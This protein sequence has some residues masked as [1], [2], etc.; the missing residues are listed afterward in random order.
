[1]GFRIAYQQPDPVPRRGAGK[2][3]F[4]DLT[5]RR[6]CRWLVLA[7]GPK[8]KG[9]T[10]WH[11]KCDCGT[12]RLVS[13]AHLKSGASTG[14][15]CSRAKGPD[16]GSFKHGKSY[17]P[18]YAAWRQMHTRCYNPNFIDWK[19]YGGRGIEVCERWKGNFEA[20]F[21]DMGP[22]P[23]PNHSLDRRNIDGNYDAIN[24]RW[25]TATQQA[26]NTSRTRWVTYLGRRISLAEACELSG[27]PYKQA[28][29]RLANGRNWRG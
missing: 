5:S 3:A 7:E 16:H 6:F 13:G 12:E 14:C 17:T 23:S 2:T 19:H 15:G 8:A 10:K 24:C 26:R 21:A 25:A 4:Q 18:E 22:R 20:F 1:M 9:N 11:C 28:Q 27:V 29:E